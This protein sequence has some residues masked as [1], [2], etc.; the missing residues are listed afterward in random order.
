MVRNLQSESNDD[1]ILKLP[2]EGK[3][4]A[5]LYGIFWYYGVAVPSVLWL[6]DDGIISCITVQYSTV[7]V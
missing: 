6:F 7:S 4:L 5:G 3:H 2:A 1:M